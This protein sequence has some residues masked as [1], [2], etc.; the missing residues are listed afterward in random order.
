MTAVSS[1][2]TLYDAQEAAN[3]GNAP[4]LW[5]MDSTLNYGVGKMTVLWSRMASVT[6]GGAGDTI[7]FMRLP[8]GTL[9]VGGWLYTEDGLQA[10]NSTADLGIVY[11]ASDGTDDVDCLLD[12]IDTNDGAD[13]PGLAAFPAGT[14]Q[15]VGH[16]IAA[17]PYLVTGGIGT[18]QLYANTSAFVTAKDSV[19]VLYV[20]LP[21][22]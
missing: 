17:F 5:T 8:P 1:D 3:P 16:D 19:L 12:G 7:H 6:G 13:T 21:G 15:K 4:A 2:G 14:I 20:V 22:Y 10:D 18:V 9:I 11:E